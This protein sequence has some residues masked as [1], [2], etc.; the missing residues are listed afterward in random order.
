MRNH[1]HLKRVVS[2]LL[3]AAMLLSLCGCGGERGPAPDAE[4]EEKPAEP[5]A[6]TAA[7]GSMLKDDAVIQAHIQHN[8]H[9]TD[10][11]EP[12]RRAEIFNLY[13][14]NN[15][16]MAGLVSDE[17]ITAFQ[18]SIQSAYDAASG[19]HDAMNIHYLDYP[20]GSEEP[21]WISEA[22]SDDMMRNIQSPSFYRK[23]PL[24]GTGP[25][26]S[27][28]RQGENP[29]EGNALTLIIS[30]F[31]EPGFDL[32]ALAVGIEEYFDNYD[33]S[34]ACVIGMRG[35]YDGVLRLPHHTKTRDNTTFNIEGFQ[36]QVPYYMVV[37]GPETAVKE[38][39]KTLYTYLESRGIEAAC[40][41]YTNSLYKQN[42]ATPLTFDVVAD[43]KSQKI[44]SPTLYSY[45]TGKLEE[46]EEGNAYA[47]T[48]SS[49][50]SND[51]NTDP[52][53]S[54]STSSQISLIST[55]YDG[56]TQYTAESNLYVYEE[57][58][59]GE[60]GWVDAGKNAKTRMAA[61]L[62]IIDS[63][64]RVDGTV[65]DEDEPKNPFI[66]P[67]R[68]EYY[69]GA[70]LNFAGDI[71]SRSQI[72]RLEVQITL[73]Q[74]PAV[75]GMDPG[76]ALAGF[77]ISTT[78]YYKMIREKNNLIALTPP[79]FRAPGDKPLT[80][81]LVEAL[82]CTP[83]LDTFLLRLNKLQDKYQDN[84]VVIQYVDFIFNLPD[85]SSKR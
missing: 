83:N 75:L 41:L 9:L 56:F 49:I 58:K 12:E 27:M 43:P 1:T 2:L 53:V 22:L 74:A 69:L 34:A 15:E 61:P 45:N 7:E 50:E 70:Q 4:K 20:R 42:I 76:E 29:F 59:E 18:E 21:Q 8:R 63:N 85:K 37:V 23:K 55:N 16:T 24:P 82:G 13:I 5:A 28:F 10:P 79:H 25:L 78:D 3:L 62:R 77:S 44:M 48:Y 65:K 17:K 14:T 52:V 71:L 19:N 11:E 80:P 60:W 32:N 40:G 81:R 46:H 35:E 30:N 51:R 54:V 64:E 38:Y 73:N 67:G 57:I 47:T 66:T 84:Q 39:Q 72:Y 31:V 26:T 68:T 36:G 6:A 33:R